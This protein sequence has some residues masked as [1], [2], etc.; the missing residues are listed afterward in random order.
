[1]SKKGLNRRQFLQT[2]GYAT[3]GA[4]AIAS[5]AVLVAPD[6]A[7]ALGLTKLDE[8]SG[9]TILAMVREIYPHETLADMYYAGVVGALD[10]D[11]AGSEDTAK[12]LTDGVKSLDSAKGVNF[13][14]LS[15]GLKMEVLN[16]MSDSGFFQAVRGKAVVA[17]Y[18]NPL[19]WRHFGY[20]GASFDQGGYLE[21]GFDD[22][23]WLEPP[24]EDAS[25]KA[26]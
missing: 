16:G 7:W 22:L 24:S 26:G 5:G 20:E 25:P 18:N 17:L 10:A 19:V 1:M 12:M 14:D 8:H 21:R 4:A 23:N 15:D 3:A 6:G 11:A 9:K 2:S 13:V